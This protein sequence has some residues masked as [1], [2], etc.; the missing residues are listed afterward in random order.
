MVKIGILNYLVPL[1]SSYSHA[2][3]ENIIIFADHTLSKMRGCVALYTLII[4]FVDAHQ[5]RTVESL[6]SNCEI[7]FKLFLT[8]YPTS[9]FY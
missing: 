9:V 5:V 3:A 8:G 4:S 6:K 2:E 1:A 7:K